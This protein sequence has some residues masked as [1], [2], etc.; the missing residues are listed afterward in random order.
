VAGLVF[1]AVG[2]FVWALESTTS[3][4]ATPSQVEPLTPTEGTAAAP[5]VEATVLGLDELRR[6]AAEGS[7]PL[8]WAGTREGADLE[9]TRTTDGSTYVR[10]LTGSAKA[11]DPGAGYVVVAT[12]PQPD[13]YRR[14]TTTARREH[15]FT[16]DL[17]RKGLAVIKPD[18]PGNIYV[19]YPGR[20]YQVEV[21]APTADEAR[22][23]VFGG[24]IRPLT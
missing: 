24:A 6:R 16:A 14:V 22:E 9:L 10:Y 12:Y 5:A 2:I 21:Y 20:P 11:G 19:V 15:F 1:A 3:D 18:R 13:A 7:V 23:L 17:P 8:Y 4:E